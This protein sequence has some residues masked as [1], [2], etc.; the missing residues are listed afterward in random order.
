MP[1]PT[2]EFTTMDH[3]A[4]SPP[5]RKLSRRRRWIRRIGFG[6]LIVAAGLAVDYFAYPYG[7]L[8]SG[9]SGNHGENGLW[10]RY[11]W[12]FGEKNE[13][14]LA[15]L[16]QHLLQNQITYA[17]FHVRFIKKDGTLA[18]RYPENARKIVQRIHKEAPGVQV[19]AWVYA[20]N[21]AGK[22][23][24]DLTNPDVRR[25]MVR[26]A[27]W[28]TNE[29]QFDG[30]QWDYEICSDGDPGFLS[31]L[32][33]TRAALHPSKIVGAAV[34]MWM[35]APLDRWGWSDR[36]LEQVC[37]QC[38]QIA[39]MGY[40]SGFWLP[41]SYVWL[42]SQQVVHATNAAFRSNSKCRVTIGLPTYGQAGLSHNTRAE[43]LALGIKGVRNG[44]TD[45]RAHYLSFAGIA[46][47]ADYTT[48][49]NDWGMYRE[50]WL[51]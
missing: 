29:C 42:I 10:L 33:E 31:L 37:G 40:D 21:R 46:I 39:V 34:P 19:M 8:A 15:S 35:P 48:D 25:A 51:K 27:V 30:V 2:G 12:Y 28:L 4:A 50:L 43:N 22:G 9:R 26:E 41:R 44:V 3:D 38:D 49:D 16:P 45:E 17:W 13:A 32:R 5:P 1:L 11:T 47:F 20:G 7:N 36:Y 24:V 6:G 18:Y 14:E 23:E